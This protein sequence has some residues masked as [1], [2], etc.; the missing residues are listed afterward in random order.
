MYT[1]Y[2]VY[3]N[4]EM[5]NIQDDSSNIPPFFLNN[6]VILNLI[7]IS[8]KYILKYHIVLKFLKYFL[9][10]KKCQF[11]IQTSVFQKTISTVD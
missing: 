5:Q 1:V 11:E 10:L 8:F 6:T 4:I 2:I 9:V 7:F 3:T